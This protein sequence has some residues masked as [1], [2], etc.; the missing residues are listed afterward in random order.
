MRSSKY[1][2]LFS[3]LFTF[4]LFSC[5]DTSPS[6]FN[7]DNNNVATNNHT[8]DKCLTETHECNVYD[9]DDG[10]NI[11]NGH[12]GCRCAMDS[13]SD[14]IPNYADRDSDN[15]G[16]PDSVEAGDSNINTYPIDSDGDTNPDYVD[17]DSDNDGVFDD[18]E[19]RNGDGRLGD[20]EDNPVSCSVSLPC[21]TESSCHPTRNICVNNIC[22]AGETDPK[23]ADTDNDGITDPNE[24]TFICNPETETSQG[25]RPVTFRDHSLN[26]FQIAME[27]SSIYS[28]MNPL[29]P[30]A[31][32]GGAAF[33]L[34]D[35][36]NSFAGFA[37]SK[38]PSDDYLV[39]EVTDL[40]TALRSLGTIT[41]FSTGNMNTSHAEKEQ[42]VNIL[43]KLN[44]SSGSGTGTLRNKVIAAFFGKTLTDF[45]NTPNS[46]FGNSDT[47]YIVSFMVQKTEANITQIMGGVATYANWQAR[48]QITFHLEDAAGG[49]CL[50]S[51]SDT[52]ENECEPFW[53]IEP[54][55][56]IVWIIDESGSMDEDQ[57]S[58][59][60]A[61]DTFL[62]VAD[63]HGLGWR[64]CVVD[65]SPGT[66]GKCC[67]NTS[68]DDDYWLV[69]GNSDHRQRF[70]NC[71]LTPAGS[72]TAD[73][74]AEFGLDAMET[75]VDLHM[76]PS[77]DNAQKFRPDAA[78][79]VFFL[80][81]ERANEVDNNEMCPNYPDPDD[82]SICHFFG[83]CMVNEDPLLCMFPNTNP[84]CK[85]FNLMTDP[86][87]MQQQIACNSMSEGMWTDP[88]CL[89]VYECQGDTRELAWE[90]QCEYL[91]D[92]YK[93]Y[94]TENE[95][96]AYGL[97]VLPGE[98]N[99]GGASSPMGYKQVI[100]ET[101]G[102]LGSLSQTDYTTTMSLIIED[103]AGNASGII[104]THTP[105]PISLIAAIERK[106]NVDPTITSFEVILRS[107]TSGF[108]YKASSN[109]IVLVGQPPMNYPP[110][111]FVVSYK[112][113]ITPQKPADK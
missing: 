93:A 66:N 77:Q 23:V 1:L 35:T 104:L 57:Q 48:E 21:D 75:T 110:Y 96:F 49:A 100:N 31:Y 26:I 56:D 11:S 86:D 70:K 40:I 28:E 95:L 32:D 17:T 27:Q 44:L 34:V 67:T 7:S 61:V 103:M 72:Q 24:S 74:G 62:N 12:E 80:T 16:I 69:S 76:Q 54:T 83:G 89:E 92:P 2:I 68:E 20:C 94:A 9:D 105:I 46:P 15:D 78:R 50:A 41:I 45:S 37:I 58:L 108:N 109:R 3:L 90:P 55:L 99:E 88:D 87:F 73:G 101:G 29:N 64:M 42:V 60:N 39:N 107:K 22:L 98:D 25:R 85:C 30:G 97:G 10:D 47:N 38:T 53:A 33:D 18:D 52:V 79:M 113:W 59:V 14:G 111:E 43:I 84:E 19:D 112:R 63:Q 102:I 91:V 51:V 65:M 81:D 71:I 8:N 6:G 36:E 106:D 82:P 4:I 13:D 5:D